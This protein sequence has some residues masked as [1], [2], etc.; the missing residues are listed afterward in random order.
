[1][2]YCLIFSTINCFFGPVPCLTESIQLCNNGCH[3]NQGARRV[4]DGEH[5]LSNCGY[6]GNQSVAHCRHCCS[7][8]PDEICSLVSKMSLRTIR[9]CPAMYSRSANHRRDVLY[10]PIEMEITRITRVIVRSILTVLRD[11]GT[12]M[13]EALRLSPVNAVC[14]S[15]SEYSTFI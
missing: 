2:L 7:L 5:T 15:L 3:G 10:R 8:S 12:F 1:M 11:S 9:L 4:P 6:L 13:H 14:S